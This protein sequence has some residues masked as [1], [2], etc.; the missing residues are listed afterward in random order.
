MRPDTVIHEHTD[1]GL[2]VLRTALMLAVPRPTVFAFFADAHNLEAITPPELRFRILTPGPIAMRQGTVIDYALRLW[3]VPIRWRSRVTTW[4]PPT[5]FVDEQER[6]PYTRWIH[7]HRFEET[8]PGTTQILDE[9]HYRLPL[10]AFGLLAR[11][12]VRQQ[13]DRI[14]R[15]RQARVRE[16]LLSNGRHDLSR[17]GPP[18]CPS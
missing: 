18:P 4:D 3:S 14:F 10:P 7:T 12:L 13:L 1:A 15:Y 16:L 11:P 2:L 8:T 17:R 5:T 6:G 9:V